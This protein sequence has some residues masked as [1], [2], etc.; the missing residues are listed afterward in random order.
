MIFSKPTFF[1]YYSGDLRM[2]KFNCIAGYHKEKDELIG[3]RNL[4][5]NIEKF[6]KS[7]VRMPRGVLLYGAPGVGKT[8]MARAI[9]GDDISLV[10]LRSADCTRN[11]S[12]KYVLKA[13]EDARKSAPCILLIDEL[14]KITEGSDHYYMEGNDRIMKVLLQ[15]LDG[16]KDNSGV[17][18]V[19]TCNRCDF[20]NPALLRSGRF[21]RIIEI[22]TPSL[23][24]RIEI[25]RYYL[26]AITLEARLDTE[27]FGKVT[28]GYSGAQL[29]CVINEAGVMAMQEG[30]DYID[31]KVIQRAMNRIAF[32]SLEG[33]IRDKDEQ[34]KT[35]VHEAGHAV[36][37]LVLAPESLSTATIIPQGRVRGHVR[38]VRGESITESIDVVEDNAVIALSGSAAEEIILGK[39]Y[40]SSMDDFTKARRNIF[41]LLWGIGAYGI[42]FAGFASSQHGEQPLSTALAEKGELICSEKLKE[43]YNESTNIISEN[44]DLVELIAHSLVEKSTLSKDDLLS[45]YKMKEEQKG[46]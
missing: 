32:R 7:G 33:K 27:Y 43:F 39:R 18:V 24:D 34:W 45:L 8:V 21:D 35:A 31:M 23:E 3:L 26:S 5:L 16:Q 10:E 22:G 4:L 19:A 2:N 11:D 14:D 38:F 20:I 42:E 46:A 12:E 17:M 41:F 44:K 9:A 30:L 40:T 28:S 15:E 25:I 1:N 29:E 6:R 13:F 37:A 36:A